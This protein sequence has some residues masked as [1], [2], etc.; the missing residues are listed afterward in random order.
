MNAISMRKRNRLYEE[1]GSAPELLQTPADKFRTGTFLVIIDSLGAE[2]QKRVLNAIIAGR[3]GFLQK[4]ADLSNEEVQKACKKHS[5][6]IWKLDC[7]MNCCSA[8]VFSIASVL[9]KHWI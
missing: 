3:F 6:V 9:R 7:L 5:L 8:L 4:L 1:P 2:L